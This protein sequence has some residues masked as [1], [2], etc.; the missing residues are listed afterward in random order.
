MMFLL[1]KKCNEIH[2]SECI[3]RM[4]EEMME[5]L[6]DEDQ[7]VVEF[8][9]QHDPKILKKVAKLFNN[10]AYIDLQAF[11]LFDVDLKSGKIASAIRKKC[12]ND[13]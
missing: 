2:L 9:I 1:N 7:S 6:N 8:A 12:K 5:I 3:T 4:D 11:G 10:K 13:P